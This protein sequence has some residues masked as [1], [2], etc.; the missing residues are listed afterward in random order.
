MRCKGKDCHTT[1]EMVF[2][3]VALHE[4]ESI[5]QEIDPAVLLDHGT[6]D[7]QGLGYL[8]LSQNEV[9]RHILDDLIASGL[10]LDYA[11]FTL[12]IV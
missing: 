12:D 5:L 7:R 2:V 4:L 11:V 10:L 3:T 1:E 8:V 9:T 6:T